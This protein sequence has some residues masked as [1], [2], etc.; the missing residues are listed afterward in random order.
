MVKGREVSTVGREE[1][2]RGGAC[3]VSVLAPTGLLL[4]I[5]L[6][7]RASSLDKKRVVCRGKC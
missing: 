3:K 6:A 7:R 5:S 1:N 2:C 4:I